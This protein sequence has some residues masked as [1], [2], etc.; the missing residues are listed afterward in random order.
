LDKR[1]LG[2]LAGSIIHIIWLEHGWEV[3]RKFFT[4]HNFII[5][6]W[7]ST[8]SF[9]VGIADMVAD[10][11]TMSQI[12]NEL[13]KAKT[14]VKELVESAQKGDLKCQPGKSMFQ[15]FESKVNMVLNEK[16]DKSG[17]IAQ[18]SLSDT[19][20]I[21]CMVTAGSKGSYLNISQI[22]ACVGQQNVIGQRIP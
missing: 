19:N 22:V 3:S 11:D 5:N 16:R 2:N 12:I 14:E 21:K 4:V 10:E 18:K 1:S 6:A 8:H 9:T 13:K 20:N 7:L 15:S 17:K